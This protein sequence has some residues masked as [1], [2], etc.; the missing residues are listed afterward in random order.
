MR[1]W[2]VLNR[3]F[4]GRL[5]ELRN[6]TPIWLRHPRG[7]QSCRRLARICS[8]R[9]CRPLLGAVPFI[10]DCCMAAVLIYNMN[11]MYRVRP[12]T[13]AAQVIAS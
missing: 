3:N 1:A 10:Q 5:A 2:A 6:I 8:M 11:T 7:W 9:R 12:W 13:A 4:K